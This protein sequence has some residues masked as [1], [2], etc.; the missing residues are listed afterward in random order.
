MNETY[1]WRTIV[2][3]TKTLKEL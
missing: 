2:E 1:S 3:R